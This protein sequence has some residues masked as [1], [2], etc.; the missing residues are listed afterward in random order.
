[1]TSAPG[2]LRPMSHPTATAPTRPRID[3]LP[4]LVVAWRYGQL[5][6]RGAHESSLL[7]RGVGHDRNTPRLTPRQKVVLDAAPRQVAG[8]LPMN[9]E[10]ISESISSVHPITLSHGSNAEVWDTDGKRYIDFNSQ[11]MSVN[12]GHG[13]RR[14][15]DAITEQATKLQYVQPAFVTEIRAR[16]GA[17]MAEILPGAFRALSHE[18]HTLLHGD[19]RL[20]NLRRALLDALQKAPAKPLH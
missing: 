2:L 19:V 18:P 14:V 10:A 1:M 11:L 17:K 5:P 3:W 8:E 12:I 9:R 15:I 4:T 13:D 16:L 6:P 7:E 20:D